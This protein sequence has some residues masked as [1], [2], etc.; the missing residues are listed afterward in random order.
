MKQAAGKHLRLAIAYALFAG[1]LAAPFAAS[2]AYALPVEGANAAANAA[3][4][5]ITQSGTVMDINGKTL[6]NILR[7][8]D[9]SIDA[10]EKVRF[11]SGAQAKD[12]LNF[13]TSEA[14]SR[15]YGTIEGGNN[16]YLV[17]PHGILFAES[18]QVNTGALYLSTALSIDV[19]TS[20]FRGGGTTL[21]A[22][23]DS[24]AMC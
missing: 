16:V 22:A 24:M 5:T 11:D 17:N 13:V 7:W 10:G 2:P 19:D 21:S 4:A 3:E 20:V 18:A 12:Y 23:K 6:N 14:M 9:F 15:I 8:E 1:A